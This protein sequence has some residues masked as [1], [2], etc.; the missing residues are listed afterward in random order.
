V[1]FV[2][3]TGAPA[4]ATLAF[5]PSTRELDAKTESRRGD[6]ARIRL[7]VTGGSQSDRRVGRRYRLPMKL[8]RFQD[9]NGDKILNLAQTF[10]IV[11]AVS[12]SVWTAHV[13]RVAKSAEL[14]LKLSKALDSGQAKVIS[15]ALDMDGN[16][17][18]N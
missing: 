5:I 17:D 6:T 1:T 15:M 10:G 7:R 16:L 18:K 9:W 2:A 11:V 12:V 8:T 4:R 3:C 14:T 13:Q